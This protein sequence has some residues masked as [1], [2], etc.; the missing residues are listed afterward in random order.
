MVWGREG[1][2]FGLVRL[3]TDSALSVATA[4]LCGRRRL[5]RFLDLHTFVYAKDD[6]DTEGVWAVNLT[7]VNR[8]WS[9]FARLNAYAERESCA[10]G[11]RS[12]ASSEVC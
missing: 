2:N 9:F 3:Q 1:V 6:N 5:Y 7:R 12:R 11:E 8:K 4:F 10:V